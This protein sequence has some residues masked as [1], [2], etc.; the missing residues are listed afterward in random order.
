MYAPTWVEVGIT[1]GSFGW[2]FFWFLLFVKTLPAIAI[3]EIKEMIAPPK[4]GALEHA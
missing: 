2:F 3:T 4:K 1:V